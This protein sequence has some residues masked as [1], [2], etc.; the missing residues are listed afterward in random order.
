MAHL[1][2]R[3]HNDEF[4]SLMDLCLPNWQVLRQGLNEAP[5]GHSEWEN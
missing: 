1:R 3:R 4:R 2:V 5:L